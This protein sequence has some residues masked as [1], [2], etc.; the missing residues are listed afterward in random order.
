MDAR[1]VALTAIVLAAAAGSSANELFHPDTSEIGVS[2]HPTHPKPSGELTRADVRAPVMAAQRDGTLTWISRG[3]PARYPLVP[4][5][6]LSKSRE[7]VNDEL[8]AWKA[9]P[10]ASDGAR[11]VGGEV[12]W[13]NSP[14]GR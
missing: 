7:Q 6:T 13:I 4:G 12:G 5:P 1:K 3:Y 9:N 14:S 10:V 2:I 8:R 11:Y